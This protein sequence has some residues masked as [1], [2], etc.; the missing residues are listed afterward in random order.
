MLISRLRA[1]LEDAD[2]DGLIDEAIEYARRNPEVFVIALG[3]LTIAAGA[4]VFLAERQSEEMDYEEMTPVARI[5][6]ERR[7]ARRAGGSR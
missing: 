3:A 7:A 5:S 6:S 1:R 2:I 4:V